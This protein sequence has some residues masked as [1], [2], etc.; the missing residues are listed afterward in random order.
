MTEPIDLKNLLPK[1]K[2]SFQYNGSL[3]TSPC[4]EDVK[5]ALLK[6]LIE[7]SKE[8]IDQFRKIFV[9]DSIGF[10]YMTLLSNA[11]IFPRIHG[12]RVSL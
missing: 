12:D 10:F 1:E 7:I 11:I 4:S 9:D 6:E 5:W 3:T 2:D 8:Q